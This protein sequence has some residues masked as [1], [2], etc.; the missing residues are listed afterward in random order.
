M[1]RRSVLKLLGAGCVP[2]TS[3]CTGDGS[4][5]IQDSDGD[6]VIDSEDYAPR[7]PDVQE[8]SDLLS[9]DQESAPE[10]T[11]CDP[12][13]STATD[14]PTA[15]ASPTGTATSRPSFACDDPS[16]L[17]IEI[18]RVERVEDFG[19][20]DY[21]PVIAITNTA[22]SGVVSHL[23]IVIT[24]YDENGDPIHSLQNEE[25]DS[26]AYDFD[27]PPGATQTTSDEEID[28]GVFSDALRNSIENE[29]YE[30]TVSD[31]ECGGF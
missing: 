29:R 24:F 3:G 16:N 20:I 13:T 23:N 4:D 5:D 19:Q 8:K 2:I 17:D 21:V 7:D 15:T 30:I 26:V 27:I 18:V 10:S 14:T 22:E 25:P 12:G 11:P 6:G 1:K 9:G 28:G 31:L